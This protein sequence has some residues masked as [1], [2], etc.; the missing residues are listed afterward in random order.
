[1]TD[2]D[3]LLATDFDDP[4]RDYIPE[5]LAGVTSLAP[6]AVLGAD[7]GISEPLMTVTEPRPDLLWGLNHLLWASAGKWHSAALSW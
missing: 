4:A 1:M 5:Q 3:A 7:A 2:H 6:F